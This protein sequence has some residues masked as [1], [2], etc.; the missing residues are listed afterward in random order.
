[1]GMT[2]Q[3]RIALHKKQ[4]RLQVKSGVPVASDLAEGVPV[5]RSTSEGVVEYVKFNGSIYKSVWIKEKDSIYNVDET[6]NALSTNKVNKLPD[7]DSGW[8]DVDRSDGAKDNF[9]LAHSLTFSSYSPTL[10]QIFMC[11]LYGATSPSASA[12]NI[13]YPYRGGFELDIGGPSWAGTD[14]RIDD[15]NV[16]IQAYTA[17]YAFWTYQDDSGGVGTHTYFSRIGLRVMLWE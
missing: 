17:Y 13:V 15:T 14:V 1:M 5:L 8:K 4:E 12:T 11:D 10:C 9:T 6:V 3:E 7:Y 2:R 16:Y